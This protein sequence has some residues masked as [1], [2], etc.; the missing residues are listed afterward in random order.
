[1]VRMRPFRDEQ[2][3]TTTSMV[4]SMLVTLALLFS[5]AQVYRVSSASAEVQDVADAAALAAEGQVAEFMIVA[6]YCDAIVLSL[7]LTGAVATGLGIAALCTPATA[8]LSAALINAGRN[9]FKMR[10]DFADRAS[11]ALNKLQ[12]AL[13]FLSAACA[14]GVARAN[15]GSSDEADYLGVALLVPARGELLE[16]GS[17]EAMEGLLDEVDSRADDIREKAKRAEETAAEANRSKERAFARDCGDNP[18][19]CMYERASRLAGLSGGANPLFTSV[20]AWTFSVPLSR[21]RSYYRARLG[22]EA[23]ASGSIEE[24]ARSSLREKFYRY[25]VRE[26]DE[27]YVHETADSFEAHIPHLPSNTE[28][29]RHTDLYTAA[30]YPVTTQ[31]AGEGEEAVRMVH[32]WMGC[33]EVQMHGAEGFASIADMEAE[34]LPTCPTCSFTAASLGKVAAASTSIANGF[35]YHYEAV[36][37]EAFLYEKAR[38]EAE[39][40]TQEVKSQAGELFEELADAL[41][42]SAGKRIEPSPPGRFGAV[43]FVVNAGVTP[44]AGRFASGFARS[45][46]SLGPRAAVSAATLVDEGSEE[47]RN[48]INSALDGIRA[49]GGAAVGAPGMVLD[50]WA[51]MLGAYA[52]GQAALKRGVEECLNALPLVGE[53]GLGTWAAER[54]ESATERLGL[55]P[56]EVGALKP[57]LVNSGHVASRAEGFLSARFLGAKSLAAAHLPGSTDLFSGLLTEAEQSAMDGIEGLG[58]SIEIASIELAGAGGVSIPIVI[59][60]PQEATQTAASAVREL[61]GRIGSAYVQVTGVR[62][63]E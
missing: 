63:W 38:H 9:L 52:S 6:R 37:D 46:G 62:V 29:M 47:G 59:P 40:P 10:N 26:L 17:S 34:D 54:L 60:L 24:Q 22:G 12:E 50:A 45:G 16:V 5:A 48:V 33:P 53:S 35:E 27:G 39:G 8:E 49:N 61:I 30:V 2:G 19:Y 41:E 42:E 11:A 55:Q 56:A 23:P 7:T 25:A 32:A 28:E 20:D 44:S 14:A 36:A 18:D 15:D 4:L 57:V 51:F 43:A 3:F 1:M 21:A 58:D 31:A 13:P